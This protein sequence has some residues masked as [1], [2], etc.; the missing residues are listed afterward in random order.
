[1]RPWDPQHAQVHLKV[2][3]WVCFGARA[4]AHRGCPTPP[5]RL[6]SLSQHICRRR[7]VAQLGLVTAGDAWHQL[8]RREGNSNGLPP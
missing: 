4:Q 2:V 3:P 7:H 6:S 5:P 8:G 1:M